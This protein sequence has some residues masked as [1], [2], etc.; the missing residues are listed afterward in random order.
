M[1]QNISSMEANQQ[2]RLKWNNYHVNIAS[3]FDSLRLDEDFVD[4]TVAC[5]GFQ[6]RAHK[7]VLSACSPFFRQLLKSNPH[8]HPIVV[9]SDV[10]Q[11]NMVLLLDFMY[12]GEVNVAQEQLAEF[13]KVAKMLKVKGLADDRPAGDDANTNGGELS[14]ARSPPPARPRSASPEASPPPEKRQRSSPLDCR[15]TPEMKREP[16]PEE[17]CEPP[18]PLERLAESP[19]PPEP[20]TAQLT[21]PGPSSLA[22]DLSRFTPSTAQDTLSRRAPPR[23]ASCP[24]CGRWFQKGSHLREHVASIHYPVPSSCELCGK[25]LRSKASL[26]THRIKYHR[27]GEQLAAEKAERPRSR[28]VLP[29][30]DGLL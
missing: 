24:I 29:A 16:T 11:Q 25:L 10:S 12:H 28:G 18:P 13:L 5:D 15:R 6:T 27:R 9:L 14:P 19:P 20:S 2:F 26:R 3:S 8:P 30:A 22:F 1:S 7:M 21:G 17:E 23:R 4:V